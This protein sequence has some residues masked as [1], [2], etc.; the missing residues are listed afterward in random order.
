MKLFSVQG[1]VAVMITAATVYGGCKEDLDNAIARANDEQMINRNLKEEMKKIKDE[2]AAI[3]KEKDAAVKEKDQAVKQSDD[4]KIKNADLEKKNKALSENSALYET[5]A[6]SLQT[7]ANENSRLATENMNLKNQ[8]AAMPAAVPA[9][10]PAAEKFLYPISGIL[11]NKSVSENKFIIA[12]LVF[13]NNGS[14]TV[15][16]F[17][18]MLKFYVQGRKI[19]EIALPNV[20][21][22][23]NSAFGRNESINFRAGLPITDQNLVNAPVESIDLVVEVTKIQ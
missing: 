8:I 12:D 4:L 21:N 18:C 14:K 2:N 23:T 11:N 7:L 19:Y 22:P 17:D 16:A 20:K 13:S 10:A 9:P 3:K 5:S 1:I 15:S 6:G